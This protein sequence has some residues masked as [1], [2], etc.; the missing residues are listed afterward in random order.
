MNIIYVIYNYVSGVINIHKS[1]P[2]LSRP[3]DTL[4]IIHTTLR[5]N[6]VTSS[7]TVLRKSFLVI[8]PPRASQEP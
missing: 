5:P 8:K 4:K 7:S 2:S 6:S 1:S 3:K